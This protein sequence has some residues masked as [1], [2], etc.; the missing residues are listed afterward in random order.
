MTNYRNNVS[1]NDCI[2]AFVKSL[3]FTLFVFCTIVS[4]QSQS[5]PA[6][7]QC[8]ALSPLAK[9]F[10]SEQFVSLFPTDSEGKIWVSIQ[11]KNI[12]LFNKY[13]ASSIYGDIA[14]FRLFP[15]Q[16]NELLGEADI[17]FADVF[18]RLNSSRPLNDTARIHSFVNQVHDG[19]N[20]GLPA[21]IK[22]K[23]VVCGIVDIGFQTNHPTFYNSDGTRF[24]L[25]RFWHQNTT[26]G[27]KPA[28]YSYGSEFTQAGDLKAIRDD[29]GTHGTHV[30]GIM[31]GSGF[32][33]P[34]LR[35]RGMA[36]ESDI[37]FVT[38]KYTNDSLQG[39]AYGD[40]VVANPTILDGYKY[41]FDYAKS[42]G[43]P[44]VTNLSWGM[45]TGP[46][47]GTSLFDLS[48]DKMAGP[49]QILVG[50][51][52]NDAGHQMHVT[53]LLDGDTAYTFAIDR[54]RKDYPEENIYCDFWGPENENMG[55]NISVFDTL[56]NLRHSEPFVYS[57]GSHVFR[58]T[59]AIGLND[60][61]VYTI[62][63]Q[64]KYVNNGKPNLLL[65][66]EMSNS[67][68]H[69]LRIGITTRGKFHGWNSGQTYRWTSGSFLDEVK[70]N[71]QKGKYLAGTTS[72]SMS[73]NG[74]TGKRT[75]STGSYINRKEW[76]DFKG[77]YRAQNWLTVGEISGF[78][79]R[80]PTPD[81]RMKPDI[82]APGQ[83]VASAVNNKQYAGWMDE[84]TT[85]TS[86]F[87]GET[88]YWTMFSG[89]SMA[90]PHAAGIVALMLEACPTLTPEQVKFILSKT[91]TRDALTGSDSNNN[92]GYGRINAFEAVK[93]ALSI[94]NSKLNHFNAPVSLAIF[95]VPAAD[96][97]ALSG[98]QLRFKQAE[99]GIY[100][101]AGRCLLNNRL[102]F[103]SAGECEL[104]I[105]QLPAGVYCFKLNGLGMSPAQGKFLVQR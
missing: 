14:Y 2:F 103:D 59:V 48:V 5:A 26:L 3:I 13:R 22:G 71:N 29:D 41:I 46:H 39:S 7:Q 95:P 97:L 4:A 75:I 55:L 63:G 28:G 44:A 32:T 98:K 76:I 69:R 88:Q 40:Y 8:D 52:G 51:N 82:S 80:G 54:N 94:H 34:Q 24:R 6:L 37:V 56:G 72:V 21:S 57:A 104:P 11:S 50:A 17:E 65:M 67:A 47:D 100:D 64:K 81:G 87:N 61:L 53:G 92:Y 66:A 30:A 31:A 78:S 86:Q 74:G 27:A 91:S 96:K 33:T 102:Q 38:I 89:T 42:I 84:V 10:E 20:N 45:H 68:L 101:Q 18:G 70:G 58:K 36:P 15:S 105:N 85:Y 73:E 79:S 99:I 25:V 90:S 1:H 77:I 93:A 60:T 43:K 12:N 62:V 19:L 23:G 35:Y 9:L 83:L 16:I 49:G